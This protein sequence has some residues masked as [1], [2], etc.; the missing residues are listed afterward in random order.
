MLKMLI[1]IV[2]LISLA[3]PAGAEIYK[4][5]LPDGKTEISNMPCPTGSGTLA[6]RP[7]ERVPE[8]ARRA[9]EQEVERMRAFVEKR[10]AAQRADETAERD[11]Q[12]ASGGQPRNT[13]ASRLPPR[14]VGNTEECLRQ[15]EP[16]VLE[17]N[18][19]TQMEA[20]CR[21]L[22]S[23]QPVYQNPPV[24]M[25]VHPQRLHINP[26]PAALPR[27]EPPSGPKISAPLIKN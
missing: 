24:V 18:Q 19:R 5:R 23:P 1:A 2:A 8:A 12:H 13:E 7:D 27:S 16:M 25:P 3:A 21:S 26:P 11:R 4:C 6:V 14:Q 22:V 10:E 17:A 20:E 9:A 15:L